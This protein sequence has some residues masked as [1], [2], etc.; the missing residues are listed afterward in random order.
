MSIV[1]IKK[2]RAHQLL[3]LKI[4]LTLRRLNVNS[5]ISKI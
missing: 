4:E 2:I 5:V 3:L 1:I